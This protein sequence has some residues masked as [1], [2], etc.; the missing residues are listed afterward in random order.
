MRKILTH[1]IFI[2]PAVVLSLVGL[3]PNTD[4]HYSVSFAIRFQEFGYYSVRFVLINDNSVFPNVK[5]ILMNPAFK[6]M[7]I[8]NEW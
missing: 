2:V 8:V 7:A 3:L 1:K 6:P 4:S 5:G